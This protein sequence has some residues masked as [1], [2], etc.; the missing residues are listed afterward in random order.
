MEFDLF[1][2]HKTID[3]YLVT[4]LAAGL[5]AVGIR[6][7]VDH[8]ER[9]FNKWT[10]LV[11]TASITPAL[12]LL[13]TPN[14]CDDV[15]DNLENEV[16]AAKKAERMTIPVNTPDVE[17]GQ[18]RLGFQFM[19]YSWI[20]WDP[21]EGADGVADDVRRRLEALD[22]RGHDPATTPA[23]ERQASQPR[24]SPPTFTVHTRTPRISVSLKRDASGYQTRKAA[25]MRRF[26]LPSGDR[27]ALT[28]EQFEEFARL[29]QSG[30]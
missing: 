12:L 17:F 19:G 2:S 26:G 21:A 29:T 22:R 15:G 28:Q 6:C 30:Q 27:W 5:E 3:D 10:D 16:L 25:I 20:R 13:L 8:I 4:Q 9:D 1:I 24:V 11:P 7:Y 23:R 14:S 18:G